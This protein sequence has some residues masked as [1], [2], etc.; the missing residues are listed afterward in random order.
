M[1]IQCK[2][3]QNKPAYKGDLIAFSYADLS[4][5]KPFQLFKK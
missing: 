5:I 1:P 2:N 3:T 4:I